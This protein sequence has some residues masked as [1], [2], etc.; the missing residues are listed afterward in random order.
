MTRDE[1]RVVLF[2]LA[3]LV[4]GALYRDWKLRHPAV[5]VPVAEPSKKWAKP[6]YVFKNEKELERRAKAVETE[7]PPTPAR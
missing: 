6:P 7:F 1:I 5:P 4:V 3:A 2:I